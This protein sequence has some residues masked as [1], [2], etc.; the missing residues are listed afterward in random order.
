[1]LLDEVTKGDQQILGNVGGGGEVPETGEDHILVK[2]AELGILGQGSRLHSRSRAG[3][4]DLVASGEV[5][6]SSLS[7]DT[8]GSLGGDTQAGEEVGGTVNIDVR[9]NAVVIRSAG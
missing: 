4:V 8:A 6:V 1:M 7:R 2:S 3:V 9:L 5:D